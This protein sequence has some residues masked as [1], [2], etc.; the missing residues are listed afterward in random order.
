MKKIKFNPDLKDFLYLSINEKYF[1][2]DVFSS[3][4]IA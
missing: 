4:P 1:E 2:A 3:I